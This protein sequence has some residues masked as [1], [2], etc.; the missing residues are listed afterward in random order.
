MYRFHFMFKSESLPIIVYLLSYECCVRTTSIFSSK[1]KC[2]FESFSFQFGAEIHHKKNLTMF[3]V[4]Q[5]KQLHEKGWLTPELNCRLHN[6]WIAFRI[7]ISQLAIRHGIKNKEK[8]RW[9]LLKM[10]KWRSYQRRKSFVLSEK[11]SEKFQ[12]G[13]S[14]RNWRFP[15]INNN[16]SWLKKSG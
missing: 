1:K 14:E 4:I 12:T 3:H 16:T 10:L 7:S 6:M 5:F 2:F 8:G 13:F 15:D 11:K 9:R